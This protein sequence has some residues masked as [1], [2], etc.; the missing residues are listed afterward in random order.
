MQEVKLRL[1]MLRD[2]GRFELLRKNTELL[3]EEEL[4]I[5]LKVESVI[6]SFEEVAV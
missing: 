3:E 5:E 6:D 2:E 1:T 4:L